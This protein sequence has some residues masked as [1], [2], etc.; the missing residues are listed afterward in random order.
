MKQTLRRAA[1]RRRIEREFHARGDA[2]MAT[3]RQDGRARPVKDVF[4]D[5]DRSIVERRR[6]ITGR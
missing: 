3:Y 4:D 5:I 6:K 2:A 1:E